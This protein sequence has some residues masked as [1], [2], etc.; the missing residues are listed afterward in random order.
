MSNILSDVKLALGISHGKKDK[1]ISGCIASAK[2]EMQMAGV[3]V[4][5]ENDEY[6]ATVIKTYCKG[7]Y[8]Y[9]GEGEKWFERFEDL[10]TLLPLASEYKGRGDCGC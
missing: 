5:D 8:N 10:R 2:R 1:E 7:I 4:V 3:R 6:T 9:Q